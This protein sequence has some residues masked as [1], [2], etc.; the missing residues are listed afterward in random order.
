MS[1]QSWPWTAHTGAVPAARREPLLVAPASDREA[2]AGR[3]APASGRG[4]GRGADGGVDLWIINV[5]IGLLLAVVA[6]VVI[7]QLARPQHF[8]IRSV[9]LDTPGRHVTR[10][11]LLAAVRPAVRG[12]YFS[13][14]IGAVRRA[15]EA[16]PLVRTARVG[17]LWPDALSVRVTEHEL[18]AR[19][20]NDHLLTVQG[21]LVAAPDASEA[22]QVSENPEA[23]AE[24]RALPLIEGP[25]PLAAGAGVVPAPGAGVGAAQ[26]Y[27]AWQRALQAHGLHMTALKITPGRAWEIVVRQQPA[28]VAAAAAKAPHTIVLLAG[29]GDTEARLARFLIG[30]DAHLHGVFNKVRHVDLRYPNGF[31]V[32]WLGDGAAFQCAAG[33]ACIQ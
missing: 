10:T 22:P 6:A 25:S 14:D 15:A 21:G 8:V 24:L 20:G 3:E 17:R 13:V 32:R 12:N 28:P 4:R 1:W 23:M 2:P 9:E 7:D 16:L 31:A 19:W 29:S 26:K 33:Y 18:L 11:Q 27:R 5:A 30:Y